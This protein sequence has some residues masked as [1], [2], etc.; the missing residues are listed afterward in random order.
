[1]NDLLTGRAAA[2]SGT[3]IVR[4]ALA[5]GYDRPG[6][7]QLVTSGF[8]VRLAEGVYGVRSVHEAASPAERHAMATAGVVRRRG[9]AFEASHYSA[10]TLMGIP[11]WHC[12]LGRVHVMRTTDGMPRRTK[13]VSIHTACGPFSIG[14]WEGVRCV[15]PAL[16]VVGTAIEGGIESGVVAADAALAS[17]LTTVTEL[18]F[19]IDYLS[20]TPKIT[21]ARSVIKLADAQ[22]ESV[23]ESRTR[24]LMHAIGLPAP[25]LQ[26]EIQDAGRLVGRVDFLFEEERVIVEF[27]GQM[28]YDG[29][30]G[31]AAL[32]AVKARED[33]L[34]SLGYEVVR[35]VW[36]DLDQPTRVRALIEAGFARSR[37][38]GVLTP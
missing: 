18:D 33:H 36:K 27:D 20:G 12:N 23:G 25:V 22:S 38:R 16:A 13:A 5:A 31:Q 17:G 10:L 21:A 15:P 2:N 4:E 9:G 34:R 29:V 3:F 37:M 1:M 11:V 8:A 24:L 35:I 28:K 7:R 32:A 19:W 30:D 14:E 26:A 6:L